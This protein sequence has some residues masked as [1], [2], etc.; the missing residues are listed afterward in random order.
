[1]LLIYQFFPSTFLKTSL[2]KNETPTIPSTTSQLFLKI[3][4][5]QQ[6]KNRF[7]KTKQPA[8]HTFF[9]HILYTKT[10]KR[11]IKKIF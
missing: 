6:T 11:K 1:M 2:V 4:N 3:Q 7:A 9:V 8:P 5:H 10:A